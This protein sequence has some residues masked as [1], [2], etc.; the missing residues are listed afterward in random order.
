MNHQI[1]ENLLLFS[2][3]FIKQRE[4]WLHKLINAEKTE[5]RF[6]EPNTE[7]IT[8]EIIQ[9]PIG[10]DR[11][12]SDSIFH[13]G[14]QSDLSVY[15][16]LLSGLKI[17][18]NKYTGCT[19]ISVGSP[20]YSQYAQSTLNDLVVIRT[21]VVKCNSFKDV[22]LEV[23][24][25]AIEAYNHQD[26][27]FK[28]ISSL[29]EF[30]VENLSE[31]VCTYDAIHKEKIIHNSRRLMFSFSHTPTGLS[32]KIEY[33]SLF[34]AHESVSQLAAHYLNLLNQLVNQT[35][36]QIT[37]I[38]L[39]PISEKHLLINK[40]GSGSNRRIDGTF[41]RHF[42][43]QARKTP[44]DIAVV[45]ESEQL[46]YSQLNEK[47]NQLAHYLLTTYGIIPGDLICLMFNRS[48]S[49]L[50][51]ILAVWKCGA[52][53]IPLDPLWPAYRVEALL[54]EA[55]PKLL[56]FDESELPIAIDPQSPTKVLSLPGLAEQIARQANNNLKV[57][58]HPSDL[59]Y[60]IYTSGSSG[61]PKG[62]MIEHIGM[63]NH[64]C[65][66][67]HELNINPQSV[68]ALN[69]S[70]CFDISVWQAFSALLIGG[71]TVIYPEKDIY[72]LSVFTTKI[73]QHFITIL[74]VVPSYLSI[75]V[76][77]MEESPPELKLDYLLVTGEVLKPGLANRWFK[78]FPMTQLVNAYGPT[79]ASDDVTHFFMQG[80]TQAQ[81]IPLGKPLQNTNIYILND[82]LE[83][84]PIG[85]KGEICVSGFGVG[86]GYL[87]SIE[88]TN[89][90]FIR[91]PFRPELTTR[92]YKTGDIGAWSPDGNILFYGRRDAQTKIWGNRIELSEIENALIMLSGIVDAVVTVFDDSQRNSYLCGYVVLKE[93]R[94]L[95]SEQLKHRL[96]EKLPSYMIPTI[97][98]EIEAI[99]LM[100]N[101]KVNR[102]SLIPPKLELKAA[103]SMSFADETEEK[104]ATVWK[105][106]LGV[107]KIGVDDNFFSLGGHSLKATKLITRIHKEFDVRLELKTV[108]SH[109]TIAGLAVI[110]RRANK[111][112]YEPITIQ[113]VRKDYN[114][115]YAQRRLW[116][117]NQLE[118]DKIAYNIPI[119][120]ILDGKLDESA[121]V[122]AFARLVDRHEILRTTFSEGSEGPVQR[123]H[124][125]GAFRSQ[126]E[127]IDLC[128]IAD[129][130]KQVTELIE[131]EETHPFNLER[132][133]LVR[134]KLLRIAAHK[135]IFLFN[136]HH[137]IAD[138]WSLEVI[139]KEIFVLYDAYNQG[140]PDPL[141]PLKVHYKDFAVWQYNQVK[142]HIEEKHQEYWLNVFAGEL[143]V[144]NLPTDNV[145]PAE[146]T[147]RGGVINF[148]FDRETSDKLTN[149][150]QTFNASLF[151]TLLATVKVFLYKYT[152]QKDLIVGSPIAGRE[153]Q[154]LEQQIGLYV[155]TLALR[156][157]LEENKSFADLIDQI[158]SH[159]LE[160]YDHQTYPFDLLVDKLNVDRDLSHSPLFDVLVVL[161][162]T[163]IEGGIEEINGIKISDVPVS[164]TVSKFDL[165]FSFKETEFGINGALEYN[166]DLFRAKRVTKMVTHYQNLVSNLLNNRTTPI[167][168]VRY[169]SEAEERQLLLGFNDTSVPNMDNGTV[170]DLFMSKVKNQ[171]NQVAIVCNSVQVTYDQLNQ[172]ADQY[173]RYLLERGVQPQENICIVLPRSVNSVAAML[174]IFKAGACYVSVD[175]ELPV[176]R[177]N[178]I[179]NDCQARFILTE[180]I[181]LEKLDIDTEKIICLEKIDPNMFPVR[182]V[183]IK[184]KS[185]FSSYIVY[186]SGS[187]G[188]P[189]GVVQTHRTLYNLIQ[190]Q[191]SQ[192]G[193]ESGLHFLQFASFGFDVSIQD[194]F[195]ALCT[196]GRLYILDNEC[197]S[198]VGKMAKIIL[199]EKIQ[200]LSMP[201]SI[202]L[203]LFE[204]LEGEFTSIK[205]IITAGEQVMLNNKLGEYL[206]KNKDL[207]F[208]NQYGPSET[209]VVTTFQL[210]GGT[211]ETPQFPPIG[212]PIANHC[213]YILDQDLELVPIGVPGEIYIQGHGLFKGYL[214]KP[215]LTEERCLANPYRT[216]EIIYK[217][218]DIGRWLP[219]GNIEFRGRNDHQ[220][221]IRGNRVEL[222]EIEVVLTKYQGIRSAV[223]QCLPNQQLVGYLVTEGYVVKSELVAYIQ[224][225]LPV[226]MIPTHFIFLKTLPLNI[227]GKVDYKA[228]PLP[229]TN[230]IGLDFYPPNTE[231]EKALSSIW[232]EV[233]R[234][235]QINIQAN[236]FKLGGNSLI[237]TKLISRVRKKYN[238]VLPL[239]YIYLY[240]TIQELANQI[241]VLLWSKENQT[242]ETTKEENDNL[243]L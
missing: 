50:E 68:V 222:N 59:A 194:I 81:V 75:M 71:K 158:K 224:N 213:I 94:Q 144:L 49:L 35:S 211:L 36:A 134:A 215:K 118:E 172:R 30:T 1:D 119:A 179:I 97:F 181:M 153:H 178:F 168:H 82:L 152:G 60:V 126:L 109:P 200:V 169:L 218:G 196:G 212:R 46:S 122:K 25:N 86:R 55:A 128:E 62:C 129:V 140:Q 189:K 23:S 177:T 41:I 24:N 103:S 154:D 236:F 138:G 6:V 165:S 204:D 210:A 40:L 182:P 44:N 121:L 132:G 85:V 42:E 95:N 167:S 227:N 54:K 58:V 100:A 187:T 2:S 10:I 171:P 66:K 87:N 226:Y 67:V 57:V 14:S 133:P 191:A 233:L 89:A 8:E 63:L 206:K 16:I 98:V 136:I 208:H 149:I 29:L 242:Q 180:N 33:S 47:S 148:S 197:R 45:Y 15:L 221:K 157:R 130:E 193:I 99:P 237:A 156:T 106:V 176:G 34:Y 77:W 3:K 219:D 225:L 104:L 238:L 113:P 101:G 52:V 214:N 80:P 9:T 79:E 137:I 17:L 216:G 240:P 162:N 20:V 18:I 73:Q 201:Y 110:I 190:W 74:E 11:Q 147:F 7:G 163:E 150:S 72:D 205:H 234:M 141:Q 107:D 93:K 142:K 230:E 112:K 239:K 56:V 175:P 102:N 184:I 155:N 76:D 28:K 120:L 64:L 159:V 90:S 88:R 173:A 108:F 229:V 170:I 207:M 174:A 116:I 125:A 203:A 83:L 70:P 185:E 160:A 91:D 38:S 202:L 243:I 198:D 192:S 231:L 32:G 131:Q 27:P 96:G 241:E 199:E 124:D 209:H 235:E 127:V 69:A 21:N 143:P 220:V 183:N 105:V 61:Q 145:R 84:C 217:T 164:Q 146:K 123:V 53:Y 161:Q 13:L 188:E 166:S 43:E 26:L 92:L 139:R 12:L 5:F 48:L 195:F 39:L 135:Y 232:A 151:I 223:V 186:T 37:S 114:T 111:E 117:L 51:C 19:D 228:L 22:L 31:V 65:A 78:L 4:Y 115:S